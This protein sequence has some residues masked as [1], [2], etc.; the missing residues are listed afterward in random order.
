MNAPDP[1]AG[2]WSEILVVL[3]LLLGG[4]FLFF[5][6]AARVMQLWQ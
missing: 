4:G 5:V 2:L 1:N 3:F 6:I